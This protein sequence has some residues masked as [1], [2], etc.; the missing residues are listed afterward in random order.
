MRPALAGWVTAAVLLAVW[1]VTGIIWA[2]NPGVVAALENV[3]IV[4]ATVAPVV[5]IAVY[6]ALGL[7]GFGK[8]WRTDLGLTFVFVEIAFA[9]VIMPRFLS[10]IF[11]IGSPSDPWYRWVN[12]GGLVA[13]ALVVLWRTAIWARAW[14]TR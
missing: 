2:N 13:G 11:G 3:A 4:V 1:A 7:A 6:T 9:G 10:A 5:F 12:I 14:H 8:W